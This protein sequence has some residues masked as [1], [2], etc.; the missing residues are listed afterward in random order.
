M[1]ESG[2]DLLLELQGRVALADMALNSLGSRGRAFA[3][4]EHD[5][6][7]A[8]AKKTLE[9]RASGMPVTII[10]DV[11]RGDGKIAK[12]RLERDSAEALYKSN[13][14]AINL[15]KLQIKVLESQIDREYRG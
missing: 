13:L 8:L 9:E 11:C 10:S 1:A 6:R 12:L 4:A 5:Y 14:E 7:V 15:Y 3:Q 2:Q